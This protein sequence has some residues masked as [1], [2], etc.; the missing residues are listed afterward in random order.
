MPDGLGA[1]VPVRCPDI[2]VDVANQSR[3]SAR[4]EGYCLGPQCALQ[5]RELQAFGWEKP[6]WARPGRA[7]GGGW[8]EENKQTSRRA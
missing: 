4:Q 6:L 3:C 5:S 2:Q 8:G 7:G 1:G